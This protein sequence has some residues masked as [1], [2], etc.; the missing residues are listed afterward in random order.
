[1][2]SKRRHSLKRLCR[3]C[4]ALRRTTSQFFHTPQH[5][6]W[7]SIRCCLSNIMDCW[8]NLRRIQIPQEIVDLICEQVYRIDDLKNARLVCRTFERAA[9]ALM[10]R[11]WQSPAELFCSPTV[12]KEY[13][14]ID[15]DVGSHERVF[16][17]WRTRTPFTIWTWLH[18]PRKVPLE[19]AKTPVGKRFWRLLTR[20]RLRNGQAL[21]KHWQGRMDISWSRIQW[22]RTLFCIVFRKYIYCRRL[23]RS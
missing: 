23:I 11:P 17:W 10:P 4:A 7:T 2:S 15:S 3:C 1:M 22:D 9:S 6:F 14:K 19:N 16:R 20:H 12:Q 13:G 21:V 18:I 5:I 8:F